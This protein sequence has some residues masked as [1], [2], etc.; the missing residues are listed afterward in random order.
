MACKRPGVQFPEGHAAQGTLA[1][2]LELFDRVPGRLRR[3]LTWDQ[4]REMTDWQLLEDG[5]EMAVYFCDPHA[6]WQRPTNENTNRQLRRWLPKGTDLSR[7]PQPR[8]DEI[9]HHLNTMPR[10]LHQ[11]SSAN[12]RYH[13]LCR[14]HR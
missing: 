9:A 11:W 2:L 13:A 6:P 12:D 3:S 8:L 10:R 4:G 14:D 1:C 5:L 7:F